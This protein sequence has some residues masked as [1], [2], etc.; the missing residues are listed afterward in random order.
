VA[1]YWGDE[2]RGDLRGLLKSH[3][4]PRRLVKMNGDVAFFEHTLSL[5]ELLNGVQEDE[6]CILKIGK[7]FLCRF[8]L[9]C[10]S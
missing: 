10:D 1:C 5:F 6:S 9:A 7:R 8:A 2:V 4:S 3:V